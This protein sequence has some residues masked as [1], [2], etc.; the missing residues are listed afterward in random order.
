MPRRAVVVVISDFRDDPARFGPALRRMGMRHDVN[1]VRVVPE[2][3]D[4]LPDQG[5]LGFLDP[6]TG[7]V[8]ELDASDRALRH[9]LL[10]A[11]ANH[12]AAVDEQGRKSRAVSV[13]HPTSTDAI[14][15]VRALIR[16]RVNAGG[17]PR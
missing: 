7:S 17:V 8:I 5:L 12:V 13:V 9:S 6:E 15:T 10:V 11:E 14:A 1:L 2:G 3:F 4:P 16:R